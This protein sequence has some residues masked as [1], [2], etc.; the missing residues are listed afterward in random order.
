MEER[1]A[2]LV[3]GGMSCAGCEA[4]VRMALERAGASDVR[5]DFRRGE[6]WFRL[7]REVD[8]EQLRQ[9]VRA[10][11][12]EPGALQVTEPLT[13][14]DRSELPVTPPGSPLRGDGDGEVPYDLVI[15]GSGGAAFSA[16][17]QA[18]G[19]GARVVM[20]ERGVIGGTCVNI[21]CVP[22]KTLLRA[23]EIYF[24]ARHHPFAG[25]DTHAG[26]VDMS[27]VIGQ[28][29]ELVA[30]LRRE[31]YESLIDEYGFDFVHGEARFVDATT[32]RAGD[33]LI[34]GRAFL[35]ATGA[36]PAIPD[37]PG[38]RE[39]DFLTSTTAL[40]L[41]RV[42]ESVA[43]IGAGYIALEMGQLFRHLGAR[44]TL[45]QRGER[46]LKAYDPEISAVVA[47]MLAEQGIEV[48]T[49]VRYLRVEGGHAGKRVILEV[50]GRQRAVE[51]EELLVATGRQ[52]NTAAL[53][54]DRAGVQVGPRGEV[55]V[56]DHLRTTVP[57]IYA[58]GDV[59]LGPQFVYV[60]AY[61]GAVAADNALGV[62]DRRVDLR[63]VPR[64]TFTTPAI[65][66]VGLTEAEARASGHA[67]RTS[68]L[69]L[70]AVPR[71]LANRETTGVF[72]LIADA[73]TGRLLG[74]HVVA[75]NAGDVIYAATLAVKFD[76]T[77]QDLQET[78]CPYLTMAEGL[79]LAALTFDVDVSRLS[80]CAG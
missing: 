72:K 54:L 33:R 45:M 58:A 23:A 32:V 40:E 1:D 64:V 62:A 20:I 9:A 21:G 15:I 48:L 25:L 75:E 71:A 7:P 4:T 38:L 35:I 78:L 52:P 51:A 68:V 74:A 13:S 31:K 65:A 17:I 47:R 18:T 60:A 77:I 70:E 42:P 27:L 26:T 28:K 63:V 10:A 43:V 73:D 41:R 11:G 6:A 57:H 44:V 14:K 37:I 12:Y 67:V 79:K 50:G 34:R 29:D 8:P 3:I 30:R 24:R 2:R 46:L 53:N 16:A 5:V 80:C 22:S 76:L 55:I 49:G 69:P 56:D 39:V 36:S 66:S 19:H 59:T 61:Q